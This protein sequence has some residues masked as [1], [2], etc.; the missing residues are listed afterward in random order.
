VGVSFPRRSPNA[1]EWRA[2]VRAA[3]HGARTVRRT[4]RVP[5]APCAAHACA[6]HAPRTGRAARRARRTPG[7][8]RAVLGGGAAASLR[9]RP[10]SKFWQATRAC[11]RPGGVLETEHRR[12]CAVI[13]VHRVNAVA[14][15]SLTPAF[16][17]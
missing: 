4:R 8:P 15:P 7:A 10:S 6:P 12:P 2:S 11:V 17:L 13:G 14:T 16:A 3:A 5:R 9:E 1:R